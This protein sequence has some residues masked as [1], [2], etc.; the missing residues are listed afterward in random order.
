MLLS[1]QEAHALLPRVDPGRLRAGAPVG[2]RDGAL[3]ALVAA[4][5]SAVEI[6]RLRASAI[7]MDRGNLVVS[8]QRRGITWPL[9]MPTDLG[10]RLLAWLSESRLW[11]EDEP[12]FP[13]ERGPL[14]P[15]GVQK[16]LERYRDGTHTGPPSHGRGE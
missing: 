16:V 1:P 3:V 9:P 5:L 13:G 15:D 10:A 12:V 8:V 7:T 11:G 6:S 2:L 14:T 4:G